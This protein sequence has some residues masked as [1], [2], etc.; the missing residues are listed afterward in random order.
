[1][2]ACSTRVEPNLR[3]RP[4]SEEWL[5]WT[6]CAI[7]RLSGNPAA[8]L[9]RSAERSVRSRRSRYLDPIAPLGDGHRRPALT[10]CVARNDSER[11]HQGPGDEPVE[12]RRGQHLHIMYAASAIRRNASI[13][14]RDRPLSLEDQHPSHGP[15][16]ARKGQRRSPWC[17]TLRTKVMKTPHFQPRRKSDPPVAPGS[18]GELVAA[19]KRMTHME[20]WLLGLGSNQQP[21]GQQQW[22]AEIDQARLMAMKIRRFNNYP[23][24]GDAPS[25]AIDLGSGP[26]SERVTSRSASQ[27]NRAAT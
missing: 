14:P 13:A 3:L 7:R 15:V 10:T 11:N 1:M 24:M 23:P 20:M 4:E 2:W 18:N 16:R 9:Q 6:A 19:R 26:Y 22:C 5:R 8:E 25:I 27:R 17:F 12:R 21:S